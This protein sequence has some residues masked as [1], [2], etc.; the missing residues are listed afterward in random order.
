MPHGH[1][2]VEFKEVAGKS[3]KRFRFTNDED[4]RAVSIDFT[5]GTV[6]NFQLEL[7]LNARVELLTLKAGNITNVKRL[8]P[9]AVVRHRTSR[10]P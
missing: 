3:I 5:D 10:K 6:L 1:R 9:A 2:I 7:D 4:F 8:R